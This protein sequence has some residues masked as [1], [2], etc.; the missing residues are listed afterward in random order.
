MGACA[1]AGVFAL[2]WVLAHFTGRSAENAQK[3]RDIAAMGKR[4]TSPGHSATEASDSLTGSLSD[5]TPSEQDD[6]NSLIQR[7][8]FTSLS[9]IICLMVVCGLSSLCGLAFLIVNAPVSPKQ[10]HLVAYAILISGFGAFGFWSALPRRKR[11]REKFE[12]MLARS[13][14]VSWKYTDEEWEEWLDFAERLSYGR[15]RNTVLWKVIFLVVVCSAVGGALLHLM[16]PGTPLIEAF[17][18]CAGLMTLP[19]L[20]YHLYWKHLRQEWERRP[21]EARTL[22]ERRLFS[23]QVHRLEQKA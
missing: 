11:Y 12:E 2:G 13:P 17:V 20:L 7:V 10:R 14:I 19:F 15:T 1:G 6:L 5:L 23:P 16:R 18:L 9:W 3:R 8:P 4:T 21:S 22:R